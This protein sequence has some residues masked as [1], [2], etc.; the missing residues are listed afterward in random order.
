MRA[1]NSLMA[2]PKDVVED[3]RRDG[4]KQSHG[5]GDQGFGDAG[6]HGAQ[7]GRAG[8]AQLLERVDDAPH[9]SEQADERRNRR[10]GGQHA[11]VALQ[12]R[13]LF[14]HP[15]LQGALQRQRIG[16]AAA[17]FHLAR[18]FAVAEIE[19][20]HQRRAPEL[21]AGGRDGVERRGL[22]ESAQKRPVGR[23]RAAGTRP[24]WK[25]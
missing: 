19:N 18:H 10:G 24:T 1:P 16:D 3:C 25:E 5:G 20:H 22:A 21:F 15:E 4:G 17:R 12:A 23:S 14:T 2:L 8:G 13:Q 6:R 11:H 7:A 9:R